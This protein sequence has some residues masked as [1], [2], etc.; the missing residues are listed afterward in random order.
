VTAASAHPAPVQPIPAQAAPAAQTTRPYVAILGVLLGS[1]I[2]TLSGRLTTFGLADVRGAVGAGFDEGSWITTASTVGQMAITFPAVWLGAAFGPRRVLLWAAGTFALAS[3]ALPFSLSLDGILFWQ[4]V[5]GLSSGAFIPLTISFVLRNLP[6][7]L[8]AYGVAAYAM[9]SEL[10]QNVAAS[11]EGWFVDHL[12]WR[13]I[14]WSNAA[15]VAPMMLCILLG[16]PREKA[17][18]AMLAAPDPWGMAFASAGFAM[19]YA[20]L[21]QGDRLDWLNSGLIVGLLLGSALM[22][23]A[24]IMHEALSARP[25][26]NL[27]FLL[28]GNLPL[29]GLLLVL[30]RL[31]VLSTAYLVPQYLTTV[32]GFRALQT[33]EVLLWIALPQLILAPLI[34]ALLRFLDARLLL[35]LGFA[36]I[37][38]ACFL[39]GGLTRDWSGGDFLPSQVIQAVG[40]SF[41]L[42]ALVFFA[43]RHL[44]PS[45]A[46]SFGAFIQTTRM[47]GGELGVGFMQTF[48]RVREQVQSNLLGLHVEA[49]AHLTDARLQGY[50]TSLSGR[51]L[52]QAEAN[53][54]AAGL[55][56]R[57][58]RAQANVLAY[59][60]GFVLL[61]WA[62]IACILI[63][64]LLR[65]A[66]GA[67][68]ESAP[69]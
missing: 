66:P 24:F 1:V 65:A 42:T 38:A 48:V 54:R 15:L 18:R 6:A 67:R 5:G 68:V 51:S 62:G 64:L 46:L 47:L 61:G 31:M 16:I 60:D 39:A 49:G 59:V 52:G 56:A 25:A 7:R 22:V 50:A 10:S 3:L 53:A 34:G 11:L 17:N 2:A 63:L 23:A 57:A 28:H 26:V 8:A 30:F 12:S 21:D 44:V 9:N 19:L 14:F 35:A 37:A 13:W 55:L 33:G 41:G 69:T 20:A 45:E 29:L 40:Q 58:V 27:Q 43:T 32:Q 36:L 4:V